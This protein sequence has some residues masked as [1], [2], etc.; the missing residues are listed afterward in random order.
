MP[1][2][3]LIFAFRLTVEVEIS[4]STDLL[5]VI[6]KTRTKKTALHEKFSFFIK[7]FFSKCDQILNGK[8]LFLCSAGRKKFELLFHWVV[9]FDI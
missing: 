4:P 8:L 1:G 3:V 5:I 7:N 2:N 6:N 9:I